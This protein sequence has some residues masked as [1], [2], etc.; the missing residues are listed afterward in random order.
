M[1]TEITPVQLAGLFETH[2]RRLVGTAQ[3]TG[4]RFEQGTCICHLK[5]IFR[6]LES[7]ITIP[8]HDAALATNLDELLSEY[9]TQVQLHWD[10]QLLSVPLAIA[11]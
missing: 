10:D 6:H 8:L 11:G 3:V 2:L 9:A 7:M 4:F 1:Q 5:V